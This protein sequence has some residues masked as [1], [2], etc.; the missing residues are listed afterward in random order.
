MRL[1][2][3]FLLDEHRASTLSVAVLLGLPLDFSI[4]IHATTSS[5]SPARKE[6]CAIPCANLGAVLG[7][8]QQAA[9]GLAH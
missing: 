9:L 4:Q 8:L 2:T 7:G 5:G 6:S 1:P 3:I